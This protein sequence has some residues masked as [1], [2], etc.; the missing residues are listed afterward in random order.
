MVTVIIAAAGRGKRMGSA[1]NKIV[2]PLAGREVLLHSIDAFRACSRVHQFI[3]VAAQEEVMNIKSLLAE[4]M[5]P[6]NWQVVEGGSE[7]Q[8]SIANALGF[9][10]PDTQII[11]V[12]DGARPLIPIQCIENVIDGALRHQAVIAA[13]AVKDTIKKVDDSLFVTQTLPRDTLWN[14]QTPQGFQAELL[15]RAYDQAQ[16]EGYLGTDDASLVERMGIPVKVVQG[17]YDN[18]KITTQEDLILAEAFYDKRRDRGDKNSMVRLGMGY[19]VHC[20]VTGRKLVLG[21]VE[22]PYSFGLEGH[23]D[24]D[25]LLHA[26]QDALLGAA[27]LGDI[28]RHFPDNDMKYKGISSLLLL[29]RVEEILGEHGYIVNNVDATVVAEKPKLSP[30]IQNMNENIAK[31]LKVHRDRINV[32]ATTTEG[33]GFAG[34]KEGIAAYAVATIIKT[35]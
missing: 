16:R 18:L 11:L 33:L 28:G 30:Y 27:G 20:L 6:E 19:D 8:Y 34:R 26:I 35:A 2:M 5:G 29:K 22:I 15:R 31:V 9:V 13:V 21:G 4:T 7:R 25:V 23:S 17:S 24:A 1:V 10:A 12:H 14:V 32:K 3:I